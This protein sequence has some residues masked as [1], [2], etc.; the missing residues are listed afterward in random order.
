MGTSATANPVKNPDL[1]GVVCNKLKV[2][3]AYPK[4]NNNPRK[5][6][7]LSCLNK[8]FRVNFSFLL[9]NKNKKISKAAKPNRKKLKVNGAILDMAS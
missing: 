1:P 7:T 3:K 5:E 9:N 4:N 2:C 6:P 8:G